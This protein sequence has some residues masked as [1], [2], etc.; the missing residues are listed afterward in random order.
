M[1]WSYLAGD[2]EGSENE[3]EVRRG[4]FFRKFFLEKCRVTREAPMVRW[5]G[6][7]IGRMGPT[8]TA[9]YGTATESWMMSFE[10]KENVFSFLVFIT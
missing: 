5:M 7:C 4:K 10:N 2:E 1:P 8:E 9:Y 3:R 6:Q